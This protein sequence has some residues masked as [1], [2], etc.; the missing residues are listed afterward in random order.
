M[1][2]PRFADQHHDRR[3]RGDDCLQIGIVLRLDVRAP[4]HGK[5]AQLR[6]FKS[7]FLGEREKFFV[8]GI[9]AGPAAFDVMDAEFVETTRDF[10]F[11]ENGKRDAFGLRAVAEASYRKV[12]LWDDSWN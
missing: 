5:G 8:F 9:G 1:K 12:Q 3:L 6:V 2:I 7:F 11:V 4:R 10:E